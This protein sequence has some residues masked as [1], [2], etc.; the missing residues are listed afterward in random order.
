VVAK[1][2][3]LV[4]LVTPVVVTLVPTRAGLVLHCAH[5]LMFKLLLIGLI[6]LNLL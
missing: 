2:T 6:A 1:G 4:V 3:L 5:S